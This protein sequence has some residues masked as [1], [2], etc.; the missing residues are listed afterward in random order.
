MKSSLLSLLLVGALG[1]V[2]L[3]PVLLPLK[4]VKGIVTAPV[5]MVAKGTKAGL[6]NI[7]VSSGPIKIRPFDF[8]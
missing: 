4:I 1:K 3:F 5:K 7:S 6:S 2:V 8:R